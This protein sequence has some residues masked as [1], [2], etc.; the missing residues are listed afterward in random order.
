MRTSDKIKF[1]KDS[2]LEMAVG[3][4]DAYKEELDSDICLATEPVPILGK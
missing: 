3:L 1:A 4:A 2:F